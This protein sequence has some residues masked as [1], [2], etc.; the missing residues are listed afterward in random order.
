MRNNTV[1]DAW[2]TWAD[3]SPSGNPGFL[4]NAGIAIEATPCAID[5][6][7]TGESGIATAGVWVC[8]H[9]SSGWP[10]QG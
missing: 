6:K 8:M 9:P 2:H 1:R 4:G 5:P 7:P 10:C 3:V